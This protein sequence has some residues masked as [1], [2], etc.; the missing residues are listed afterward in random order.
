MKKGSSGTSL[1]PP[2][3]N[4]RG[5]RGG[6][7]MDKL[8]ELKTYVANLFD[9][10]T[11]KTTIEKSA[12]VQQKIQEVEQEQTKLREDY[13]KL[14][15]DYKDVILHTSFTPAKGEDTNGGVPNSFDPDSAFQ[16]FFID[17]ANK[18]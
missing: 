15:K 10:A 18:K 2:D 11:D 1:L 12:I 8:E 17:A 5:T 9:A 4:V 7:H 16:K 3:I 6:T 13:N 14:L